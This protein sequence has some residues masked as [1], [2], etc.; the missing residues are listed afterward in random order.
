MTEGVVSLTDVVMMT[1]GH[2]VAMVADTTI[3]DDPI[4]H[5]LQGHLS[6][7]GHGQGALAVEVCQG[8]EAEHLEN[9]PDLGHCPDRDQGHMV[10]GLGQGHFPA[11]YQGQGRDQGL[12]RDLRLAGVSTGSISGS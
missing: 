9:F 11:P 4:G 1:E 8:H 6:G 3:I 5:L 12:D 10:H 2:H 7:Q